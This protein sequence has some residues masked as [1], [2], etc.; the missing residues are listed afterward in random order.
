MVYK[1]FLAQYSRAIQ[2]GGVVV[3]GW[4]ATWIASRSKPKIT[5]GWVYAGYT[6]PIKALSA[7]FVAFMLAAL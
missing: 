2:V 1:E 4:F 6:L 3:F 7:A 5:E